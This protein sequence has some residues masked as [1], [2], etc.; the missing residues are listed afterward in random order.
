[1]LAIP[2]LYR[3]WAGQL[4]TN[5]MVSDLVTINCNLP[6]SETVFF[7]VATGAFCTDSTDSKTSAVYL[8]SHFILDNINAFNL[9]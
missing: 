2:Y 5:G 8:L 1:M 6:S 7:Q 4:Q 3:K 9:S